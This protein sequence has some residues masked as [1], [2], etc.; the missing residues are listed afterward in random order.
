MKT[1]PPLALVIPWYGLETAGGAE[2]HARRLAESLREAG[3]SIQ[4][5][6]TTGRDAFA[7]RGEEYY[8]AG[9]EQ[10]NGVPV[11]RFPLR[12]LDEPPFWEQYPER[13]PDRLAFPPAELALLDELWAESNALYAYLWEH[14]HD[15]LFIFMPYPYPTTFWGIALLP[16]ERTFLIPCLHDEPYAYYSTYAWVFRRVHR[17]LFNSEAERDLALRLY[18]LPPERTAVL[19]EGVDLHWQG[20]AARFR[21]RYGIFPPFLL[22][23]GRRDAGKGTPFLLNAFCEY[24]VRRGGPLRLV[25]AGRNPIEIPP[26]FADEVVDLGY[27]P[28][29][30]KHDALAAATL[31]VHPSAVESFSIALMEAWLQGTPALVN[32]DCTVLREHVLRSGG[33]LPYVGYEEFEAALDYLLARPALREAMG[34]RGRAYVRRNFRWEE[35]VKRFIA[36]VY[37]E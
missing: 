26:G 21:A 2:F 30:E 31:F 22:Y 4:V 15:F 8:P 9:L 6:T 34:R 16:P 24:K 32:G 7:T 23:V 36:A 37:G 35:V 27:L 12:R 14:R 11:H 18:N 3:L 29:Q 13:L 20:D 5:L 25:L 19:W 10:I 28:E 1:R 17:V 33:G